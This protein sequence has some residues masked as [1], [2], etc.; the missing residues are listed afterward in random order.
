MRAA[1]QASPVRVVVASALVLALSGPGQ[2]AGISVFVDHVIAD[3]DVSRSAV[4]LAYMAGTLAGAL[5]LPWLGRA[6]DRFGVRPVLGG[7]ALGF[8][9]F[10]VLLACV[11]ELVGLTAGFV[12]VRA[13]GQ[14]GMSL[15]ATTAVAISVTRNRGFLLGLT[16]SAGTAGISLFPLFAERLV[17]LLGWRHTLAAEAVLIWVVVLPLALWGLRGVARAAGTAPRSG[18]GPEA[19]PGPEAESGPEAGSGEPAAP[20]E[21]RWPLRD[22]VRTSVFWAMAGGVACSGLVVTAVFFHQIALLGEQGLTPTQAAANFLPQTVAGL[23]AALL[24]GSAADRFSPKVLMCAAMALQALALALLPLVAPGLGAL[25]Y[26]MALGAAASGARAVENAALP[27]Y[28]GTANLGSLRG[29]TQAVAVAS[30]AVGPILLSLAHGWAGSYRPGV[31]GLA[32]ICALMAVA[33]CFARR[34]VPP[35]DRANATAAG[36]RRARKG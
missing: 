17:A 22:I 7:V 36:W 9:G 11:Q 8:G 27:F 10:L 28:F 32:L 34:P 5:A 4:S 18:P 24:F 29:L 21:P 3:L 26:G 14:G 33:V 35:G 6:V 23:G 30:T 20:P 15:V 12:G 16:T 2:T 1:R 13:L 19:D 25:L 31:L